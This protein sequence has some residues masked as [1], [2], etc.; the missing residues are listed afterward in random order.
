MKN[1]LQDMNLDLPKLIEDF[2]SMKIGI[3]KKD[4]IIQDLQKEINHI[5]REKYHFEDYNKSLLQDVAKLTACISALNHS[6]ANI[7]EYEAEKASL[8]EEKERLQKCIQ[9]TEKVHTLEVERLK[10]DFRQVVEKHAKETKALEKETQS[11]EKEMKEYYEN[12]LN[13]E[14][15]KLSHLEDQMLQ[16]HFEAEQKILK[17]KIECEEKTNQ[18]K[19]HASKQKAPQATHHNDIFRQKYMKLEKDSQ[20]EIA[21]LNQKIANLEGMIGAEKSQPLSLMLVKP[22]EKRVAMESDDFDPIR[23]FKHRKLENGHSPEITTEQK[24]K[25]EKNDLFN[26]KLPIIRS[27]PLFN[28]EDRPMVKIRQNSSMS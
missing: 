28:S 24:H 26:S 1:N 7:D 4:N 5:A 27:R 3:K 2:N 15:R 11:R 21:K 10:A 14:T 22:T 18:M 16:E 12:R 20:A 25:L 6:I 23:N 13:E 9:E 8:L 17:I 19:K